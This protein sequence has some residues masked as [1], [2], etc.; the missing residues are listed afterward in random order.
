M[1]R[2]SSIWHT[3]SKVLAPQLNHDGAHTQKFSI[4]WL[5]M[6]RKYTRTLT[7]GNWR[8]ATEHNDQLQAQ[9]R[10]AEG[11]VGDLATDTA[12]WKAHILKSPL[13][14]VYI[15]RQRF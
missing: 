2:S 7:F 15:G 4:Q 6:Y 10:A 8:K 3:H 14:V 5:H 11:K 9:L 1:L 13:V 12:K